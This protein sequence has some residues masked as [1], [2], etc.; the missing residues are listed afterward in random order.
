[1]TKG[2]QNYPARKA[3]SSELHDQ[4]KNMLLHT[5]RI[6]NL[7]ITQSKPWLDWKSNELNMHEIDINLKIEF[8]HIPVFHIPIL[9]M[10]Q[11]KNLIWLAEVVIVF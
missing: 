8:Q 1:M 9:H 6:I 5:L 11:Q 4:I 3:L 7:Y 10:L 2:M